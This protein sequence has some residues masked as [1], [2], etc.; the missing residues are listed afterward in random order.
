MLLGDCIDVWRKGKA[1]ANPALWK[2]IGASTGAIAGL[3]TGV[4]AVAGAFG[5]HVDLSGDLTQALAGGIASL[6]FI[7]VGG[8]HVTTSD[9]VGL[10]AKCEDSE[11]VPDGANG[12]GADP[13]AVSDFIRRAVDRTS[14]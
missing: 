14:R 11:G 9:K 5:Y 1:V 8:L 3:L 13:A 4:S 6:L 12:V 10:P 7:F 2:N